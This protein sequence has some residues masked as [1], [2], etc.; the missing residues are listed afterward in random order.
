M[1][2]APVVTYPVINCT[3]TSNLD[4]SLRVM[5][6]QRGAR[7]SP[8]SLAAADVRVPLCNFVKTEPESA[9]I[10]GGGRGSGWN[11]PSALGTEIQKLARANGAASNVFVVVQQLESCSSDTRG[12][13]GELTCAMT[14]SYVVH[15][16]IF[17]AKS[18]L[19]WNGSETLNAEHAAE[20]DRGLHA[21]VQRIP[22]TFGGTEPISTTTTTSAQ[23][24]AA[25]PES[26]AEAPLPSDVPV[27]VGKKTGFR[28][29][30]LK[31]NAKTGYALS[32]LEGVDGGKSAIVA[33]VP[34][35]LVTGKAMPITVSSIQIKDAACTAT[36][37]LTLSS[38]PSIKK[39][40]KVAGNAVGTLS[41][42]AQCPD[43]NTTVEGPIKA[44][45]IVQR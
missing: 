22:A 29:S 14:S 1:A 15:S 41:L 20:T 36:G 44:E 4:D 42:S 21:L 35:K 12:R 17:S 43:G 26:P 27:A 24:V 16:L 45:L 40:T 39:A 13:G 31:G 38:I 7:S 9:L 23:V 33:R 18:D 10:G 25:Q 32:M 37:T 6:E 34:G 30:T 28:Q 2:P 5:L 3:G 19:L 8:A 11:V